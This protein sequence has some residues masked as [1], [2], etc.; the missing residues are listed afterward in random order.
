MTLVSLIA[1]KLQES[2]DIS[3]KAF[4]LF[5]QRHLRI[6][7]V[8]SVPSGDA[9]QG[10]LWRGQGT[11]PPFVA[12]APQGKRFARDDNPSRAT[13]HTPRITRHAL[14]PSPTYLATSPS[15]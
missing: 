7:S 10:C 11:D 13:R 15:D 8:I 1:Q 9:P 5:S 2:G 14:S 12:Y 3:S 4:S 6:V